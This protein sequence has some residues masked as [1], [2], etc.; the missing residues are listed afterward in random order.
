VK[1]SV[2]ILVEMAY[3]CPSGCCIS[4]YDSMS[5]STAVEVWKYLKDALDGIR[6]EED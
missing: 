6:W 4:D 1:L 3:T 2:R 5:F